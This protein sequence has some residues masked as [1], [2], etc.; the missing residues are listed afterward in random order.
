[1]AANQPADDFAVRLDT[2]NV[3][4]VV[5]T[6]RLSQPDSA[7]MKLSI[8]LASMTARGVVLYTSFLTSSDAQ[9]SLKRPRHGDLSAQADEHPSY[10]QGSPICQSASATCPAAHSRWV[11]QLAPTWQRCSRPQGSEE[12]LE[13]AITT[14]REARASW[15][16]VCL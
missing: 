2:L 16:Q 10:L 1:M 6:A 8:Y 14:K 3:L 7:R 13:W 5:F 12:H 4:M 11:H 15:P 9:A